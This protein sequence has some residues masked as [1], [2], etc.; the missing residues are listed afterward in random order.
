MALRPR[1]DMPASAQAA[2]AGILQQLPTRPR[3]AIVL[4]SGLGAVSARWPA[5]SSTPFR[6]LPGMPAAT[7]EGHAG[8]VLGVEIAGE[9]AL[10]LQ[11]RVHFYESASFEPVAAWVRALCA[12]GIEALLL[13]NAA[14]SLNPAYRAGDLM[15]VRD[16]I[17]LPALTGPNP[18]AGPN[19]DPGPRFLTTADCYDSQLY[20]WA[21]EAAA[22]IE[23]TVHSGIYCQVAGPTYETGAEARALGRMGA[24]AVGMSTAAEALLARHCGARVLALSTITNASGEVFAADEHQEVVA[25]ATRAASSVGHILDSVARRLVKESADRFGDE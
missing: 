5:L 6:D 12:C 22:E 25:A 10:I 9:C 15:I 11:G 3:L 23:T 4:G 16:H 24:D 13:S 8:R 21:G 7:V 1:L 20:V 2:A 18:L 14:G 17:C 19:Q